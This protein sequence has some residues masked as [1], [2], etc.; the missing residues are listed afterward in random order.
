MPVA[1]LFVL[2]AGIIIVFRL[3]GIAETWIAYRYGRFHAHGQPLCRHCGCHYAFHD[4]AVGACA[5]YKLMHSGRRLQRI[6]CTCAGYHGP[7]PMEAF[8]SSDSGVWQEILTVH[9]LNP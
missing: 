2:A 6:A 7:A 4:P 5:A 9:G 8:Y 3:A 1:G